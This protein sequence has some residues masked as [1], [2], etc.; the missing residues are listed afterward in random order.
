MFVV[1]LSPRRLSSLSADT[2]EQEM[3]R[4]KRRRPLAPAPGFP[5]LSSRTQKSDDSVRRSFAPARRASP[6]TSP[7]PLQIC[8]DCDCNS[9]PREHSQREDYKWQHAAP[10]TPIIAAGPEERGRVE[11]AARQDGEDKDE[12]VGGGG[13]SAWKLH[14]FEFPGVCCLFA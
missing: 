5:P 11:L 1:F 3:K 2:L 10:L 8:E 7:P 14:R 6:P 12:D 9:L 4:R 13:G